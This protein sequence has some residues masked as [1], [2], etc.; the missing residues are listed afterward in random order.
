MDTREVRN[1]L[2]TEADGKTDKQSQEGRVYY[3]DVD[4]FLRPALL[5][6]LGRLLRGALLPNTV[7]LL[8]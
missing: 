4:L 6:V 2:D 8:V 3:E 5:G 1:K 7:L